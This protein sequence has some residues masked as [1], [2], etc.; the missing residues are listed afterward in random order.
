MC[1]L[2]AGISGE[3]LGT[4][5]PKFRA[6]PFGSQILPKKSPVRG[7]PS[8]CFF[9]GLLASAWVLRLVGP[10]VNLDLRFVR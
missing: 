3:T 4:E 2:P 1:N 6:H 5:S 9:P 7:V 8:K 10:E